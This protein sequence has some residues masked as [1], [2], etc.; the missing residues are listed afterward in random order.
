MLFKVISRQ[1][2]CLSILFVGIKE[3]LKLIICII[4]Y[5]RKNVTTKLRQCYDE[6]HNKFVAYR[7]KSD[8]NVMTKGY[9]MVLIC[10]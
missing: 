6:C 3:L 8:D 4:C 5:C 2:Q 7:V 10:R 1:K 9:F